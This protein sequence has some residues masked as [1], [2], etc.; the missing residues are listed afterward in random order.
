MGNDLPKVD[1]ASV[2]TVRVP[3]KIPHPSQHGGCWRA[4][5]HW[6]VCAAGSWRSAM[7]RSCCPLKAGLGFDFDDD[8][9]VSFGGEK[10]Q[11]IALKTSTRS[12][13]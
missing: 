9:I 13:A 7:A 8:A 5:T 1:S 12:A 6:C 2:R 3:R 10:W 4:N 11:R